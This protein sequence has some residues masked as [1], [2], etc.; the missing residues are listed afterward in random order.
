MSDAPSLLWRDLLGRRI[1]SRAEHPGALALSPDGRIA[2]CAGAGVSVLYS[3]A[4][5]LAALAASDVDTL[6][7]QDLFDDVQ[8]KARGVRAPAVAHV[9]IDK[10]PARALAWAEPPVLLSSPSARCA[11]L[12]RIFPTVRLANGAPPEGCWGLDGAPYMTL[13]DTPDINSDSLGSK[14]AQPGT[15]IQC[16]KCDMNSKNRPINDRSESEDVISGPP[17]KTEHDNKHRSEVKTAW[18]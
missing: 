6:S 14:N 7:L 3:R 12:R 18:A 16:S 2:L 10:N 9:P 15:L 4:A 5:V 13:L 11:P 8:R 17:V 1:A